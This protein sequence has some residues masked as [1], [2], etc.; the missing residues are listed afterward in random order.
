MTDAQEETVKEAS[1]AGVIPEP[2]A[3]RSELERMVMLELHGPAGGDAERIERGSVRDRYLV[4]ALAPRGTIAVDPDR[5]TDGNVDGDDSIEEPEV[6]QPAAKPALHPCSM[7]FTCV[8]V[9]EV[10][11]LTVEARWGSYQKVEVEQPTDA[12]G[13]RPRRPW[14]RT[15]IAGRIDV[16][17]IDGPIEPIPVAGA[18]PAVVVRGIVSK[19]E[20]GSLVSLF[21]VNEQEQ[22]SQNKDEAW[23]FQAKL[24]AWAPTSEHPEGAPIFVGRRTVLGVDPRTNVEPEIPLL[25]LQ[26]RRH[27]EFAVGHGV[28]VHAVLAKDGNDR[29]LD[30]RSRAVRIETA[31]GPTYDVPRVEAPTTEEEPA[32]ASVALDMAELA[33]LGRSEIQNALAPLVQAYRDWLERQEDRLKRGVDGLSEHRPAGAQALAKARNAASRVEKGIS[34]LAGNEDAAEAFRFAN[35]AMWQQRIRTSAAELR[36]ADATLSEDEALAKADVRANRSWRPFQLAFILLNLPSLTN[37]EHSE[38]SREG[39]L[40]DLLFFPTGGGKTEAYLGLTAFTLAIRRLQGEVAGHDGSGGVAVLMRYTL[41]LLTA[42]QFQRAAALICACEVLRRERVKGDSRWGETPFR[43]GLWVGSNLSPNRNRDSFKAIEDARGGRGARGSQPLQITSCP[44]CDRRLDP[45]RD[46]RAD[47]ARWRTLVFCSDS[48]GSCPFTEVR[49]NGEGIPVVTVDEELYRLLPGLV[50]AT[51]DKFAQLPLQGPLHLLFGK[52]SRRC[53]R[54]GYRS[55]ALDVY[56]E[57]TEAE[58]H[59]A[60]GS[61]PEAETVACLPL[62]PPDL[63]IQDELHLISGPL[64]TLTGLYETAIDH[65][66]TWQVNGR[67]VRPKV[68]AS[69]ATIRRAA[70]QVH[71]IFWRRLDVF[72]PPVLD[73]EDSFFARQRD[74]R[75]HPGRRYVGL[76]APGQRLIS[77]EVRVFTA[78]LAAAQKLYER[79]G[80][81]A[82]PW[83]TMVGYFNALRELGGA[84]RL[85]DDD[86]QG[87]L[88]TTDR[89]GL[90]RRPGINIQELTSRVPSSEI[91]PTLDQLSRRFDPTAPKDSPR[92]V[93]VVLS[94]NMISV[95][96]DVPRLGLMV[97]V[98][99]PKATA[100]YIQATSRVGRSAH[101]PGLVF[102][103]YNWFR[104]RDLSHYESFEHYHATF[105]R[106]VEALSVTPFSPR[107]LDRGLTAV[108]VSLLRQAWDPVADWN[109]N[110]GAHKVQC[111]A[112]SFVGS[113]V[114][115]IADRAEEVTGKAGTADFVRSALQHRLDDWAKKQK[116]ARDGGAT[117]AYRQ[118]ATE[119]ALLDPPTLGDWTLWT[120]PNSLR[121]AEPP[122][123]LIVDDKDPSLDDA[124]PWQLGKGKAAAD[125]GKTAEDIPAADVAEEAA[126]VEA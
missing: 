13:P 112:S 61:L 111:S 110:A 72:P 34:L 95:G 117:L 99:Q 93:D 20:R 97:A 96:V 78:V 120:I 66:A 75:L 124:T 74:P 39:G 43:I 126:E 89:R 35:H 15:Q 32:L 54:H 57:R 31:V 60:T 11:S 16:P 82:D 94:T 90:A 123:N 87:R 108:L 105:Y 88:R 118:K 103:I 10:R 4:G 30:D 106:H 53:T 67:D 58:R 100:E 50:I 8:V 80:K 114:K 52:V 33:K 44:W 71:A 1:A 56:T 98:G 113:V 92:P 125:V 21:L 7:G 109:P 79:W 64:G 18:F 115:S 48:F 63:I 91:T 36:R 83:M 14:Q 104:P 38:R 102:T 45:S 3:L 69:T 51:A 25:D 28:G 46:V 42:Q 121:E 85:I 41:R 49:S 29:V 40:V 84:R 62:R 6:E 27:V 55:P 73:V 2:A 122:V 19:R 81:A 107:A 37:L 119:V 65:L 26:Y 22:P 116:K 59:R 86:V 12:D 68:V 24:T 101:G 77:A 17:I 76:C 23:L 70:E 47:E 9:P 5:N